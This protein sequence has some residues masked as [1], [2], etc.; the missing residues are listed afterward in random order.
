[1]TTSF[2][3]LALERAGLSAVLSARRQGDLDGARQ[4]FAAASARGPLDLLVI[5][6]LADAIR[7]D[8]CGDV[9][10]VHDAKAKDV[11]WI[12]KTTSELDLLRAIAAARVTG[13]KGARVGVDWGSAGLELAQVALGFGAT[14]LVGPIAKKNGLVILDDDVRKVKGQG[15]VSAAALKRREIAA[16]VR[17]AGRTCELLGEDSTPAEIHDPREAAHA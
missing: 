10:R 13:A 12:V 3:G 9:V 17:N 11:V 5:G 6:A 7:A 14:D 15:M 4:A 2:I 8:E 16:L 1:V